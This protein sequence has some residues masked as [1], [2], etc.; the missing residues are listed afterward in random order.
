MRINNYNFLKELSNNTLFLDSDDP[1]ESYDFLTTKFQ[2]P[3]NRHAPLKK[4]ILQGNHDPFID[5]E[6]REAIYIRSRLRDKFL[7]NPTKANESLIKKQRN[8][9]KK[10]MHQKLFQ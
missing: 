7:K 5:K 9:T 8:L 4:K 1:D 2:E 10:E 3:V 6:F